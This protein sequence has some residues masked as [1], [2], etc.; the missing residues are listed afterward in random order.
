MSN[1]AMGAAMGEFEKQVS[2]ILQRYQIP[3]ALIEARQLR[4]Y[5]E[6]AELVIAEVGADGREHRLTPAAAAAWTAMKQAA[7]QAGVELFIVSAFRNLERQ[8]EII[9][10]KLA[11]GLSIEAIQVAKGRDDK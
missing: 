11:R 5:P 2:L 8:I 4:L 6:P 10:N 7:H 3:C 9:E 1:Q